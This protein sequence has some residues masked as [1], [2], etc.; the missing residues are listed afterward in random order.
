MNKSHSTGNLIYRNAAGRH[1]FAALFVCIHFSSLCLKAQQT[2]ENL[3]LQSNV[4]I[5]PLQPLHVHGSSIAELPGGDLISCWF[6]GS[7]ERQAND[8]RIMGAR[9]NKV[10]STWSKPFEMADTP[11]IPDCNPVLFVNQQGRLFLT[12]IAV[13]ANR[14][15][16]AVIR[17][18]TADQFNI[19][20]S[21]LWNWQDNIFIQPGKE[22]AEKLKDGLK[23]IKDPSRGWS[24][25]APSY[26]QLTIQAAADARKNSIGWMTRIKPLQAKNG[27]II[28][29]LYSD[30]FNLS[31]MAISSDQGKTW[32][33]SS[34]VV[35]RGGIQPSLIER[36]NG[37]LLALM[38]D[39]GDEPGHIKMSSSQNGGSDWTPAEKTTIPNPGSSVE[40]LKLRDGRIILVCNDLAEGRYKL[41]LYVST[42]EGNNW[43]FSGWLEHD[44]QKKD[45]FSYPAVIQASDGFIHIT[46]S[47]HTAEKGKTIQHVIINPDQIS[48][49]R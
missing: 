43:Q 3:G 14:W 48:T 29:P 40:M 23:K 5:F 22:F 9:L 32:T 28:L 4:P 44:F 25:Y 37:E 11:G 21:P 13:L 34:P 6:E 20:G 39:N 31:I 42:D 17:Y 16:H 45:G 1:L 7:G 2:G 18:R 38:R 26:D 49:G 46:Y 8:V 36:K 24:E 35:S 33:S 12:W 27:N 30:G 19:D 10:S 41:S 47:K 15:E